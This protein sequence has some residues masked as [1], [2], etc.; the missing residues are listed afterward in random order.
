MSPWAWRAAGRAGLFFA[1]IFAGAGCEPPAS[2][3]YFGTT[4]RAGKDPGTLYAN[5]Y[6]EPEHID[7]GLVL[8]WSSGGLTLQLFEGLAVHDPKDGRPVQGVAV[9]WDRSADNRVYRFYLRQNARWSDGKP[10]TAGDFEYAWKR[11]L[12]PKTGSRGAANLYLLKNA[13]RFHQ[14][15]AAEAEVGVKALDDLTLHVELEHPAPYFVDLT[16]SPSLAPVRRDVIEAFEALGS[17]A[18]WTRPESIVTNGAYTLEDWRFRYEITMV[19]NPHYWDADR[20]KIRRV[21]WMLVGNQHATMNLYKAG[22]ID[23]MYEVSLPSAYI[24][25]LSTKKDFVSFPWLGTY[26]Y[27]FNSKKPPLNDVRVRRALN[28]ATDK[29][30]IVDTIHHGAAPVATHYIPDYTGGGYAEQAAKDRAAGSDPFSTPEAIFNP[31]RAR[32]LLEEAGYVIERQRGGY[33]VRGFPPIEILYNT[34]DEHRQIAVAVQAMWKQ[35]LGVSATLRSEEW[36]IMLKSIR[37]GQYQVARLG[38]VA[39]YNHPHTWLSSFVSGDP[40]NPT[41]CG[42]PAFD[43]LLAQAASTADPA[44]SI[45]LYRKAEAMAL[46]AMCRMPIYF[47]SRSTMTKP[48]VKGFFGTPRDTHL[49]KWMWIDPDWK[50]HPE[51]SPAMPPLPF[52]EPGRLP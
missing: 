43:A 24:S 39:E 37:D 48:W 11:V 49:V 34:V 22:E 35:H 12:N 42:D 15:K 23:L 3:A 7:P 25:S 13:Q 51:S 45:R 5:A 4:S 33:L 47:R 31:E 10:V 36:R 46:E 32:A 2:D 19:K 38:W 44:E 17:P 20:V 26:W 14:G 52:P 8:D 18:S 28:L 50:A 1:A 9:R 16:C 27:L 40:K 30:Q 21:I 29:R 6:D 41:G